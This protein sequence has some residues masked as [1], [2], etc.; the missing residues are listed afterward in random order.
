MESI[1]LKKCTI[2]GQE[3]LATP[4]FFV[5]RGTGLAAMCKVCK[6]AE[7]AARYAADPEK[8][9]AYPSKKKIYL[10]RQTER[11][12]FSVRQ[13]EVPKGHRLSFEQFQAMKAK[14]QD[15]CAICQK[16]E[17]LCIDH[18]HSS[19]RVRGLLCHRCNSGLGY[20]RDNPDFLEKAIL[21]LAS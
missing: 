16:E 15:R 21:Y 12:R 19:G 3:K 7:S 20:F 17:K 14:Q 4:D 1:T 13:A 6:K 18:C 2:C 11:G 10:Q 8:H 5:R 9:R